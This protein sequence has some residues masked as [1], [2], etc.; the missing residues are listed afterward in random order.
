[1]SFRR[2]RNDWDAFLDDHADTLLLCGIPDAITRDERRFFIFLD[3]GHD[4]GGFDPTHTPDIFNASI[5]TD[6]QIAALAQ[7]VGDHLD[8]SYRKLIASRWA[9]YS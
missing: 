1:M 5:L 4:A 2:T 3:H 9:S 6:S 7:L 8:E